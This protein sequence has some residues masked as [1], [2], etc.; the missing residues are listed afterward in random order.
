MNK[1]VMVGDDAVNRVVFSNE[2]RMS[3][4]AGPCQIEGMDHALRHADMIW[5]VCRKLNIDFIYKSSFDKANRTSIHSE[6]GVGLDEGLRVL[7]KVREEVGCA[8][9]TDVHTEAQCKSAGE[10]VDMLQIPAFLSRQTDLLLAAGETGKPVNIKKGQWMKPQ[11]MHHAARKVEGSGSKVTLCERGTMFGYGDLVVDYRNLTY[12]SMFGNPVIF[13]GTHSTQQSL[14]NS[15]VT[16][17][18]PEF[19]R[20][21]TLAACAVGVAGVFLEVHEDPR[22]APSDAGSMLDFMSFASILAEAKDIDALVKSRLIGAA[23]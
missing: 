16:G 11:D 10:V 8:V 9:L 5:Q 22:S 6:R 2:L 12:M 19:S 14:P 4:I 18:N 21:L 1:I 23:S 3:V 7:Q 13:D 15:S 17:G 20:S